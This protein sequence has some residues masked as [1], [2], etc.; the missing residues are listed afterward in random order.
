MLP[1]YKEKGIASI[2]IILCHAKYFDYNEVNYE[3]CKK[4]E[5]HKWA[6]VYVQHVI[7]TSHYSISQLY[8]NKTCS[9]SEIMV[10]IVEDDHYQIE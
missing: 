5:S 4:N 1:F 3:T 6:H 2:N 10:C 8:Q 9:K 7:F